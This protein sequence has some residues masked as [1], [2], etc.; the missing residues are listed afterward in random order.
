MSFGRDDWVGLATL[1][2]LDGLWIESRW[3]WD[4]PHPFRPAVWLMLL[5]NG[6]RVIPG[7]KATK[8]GVNHPTPT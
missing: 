1:Y 3:R 7:G 2:G 6:Y 8:R 5:Y 4:F